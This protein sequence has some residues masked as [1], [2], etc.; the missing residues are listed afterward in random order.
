MDHSR[1]IDS[2]DE[3]KTLAAGPGSQSPVPK[4]GTVV[5]VDGADDA[6]KPRGVLAKL[7]HYEQL[8]DKKLG[9][10]SQSL[11]RR[12]PEGRDP[13]FRSWKTKIMMFLMWLSSCSNLCCFATGFLGYEF[14]LDL[15]TFLLIM[16]FANLFGCLLPV[17]MSYLL[18]SRVRKLTD[19]GKLC[20]LGP[21]DGSSVRIYD[22]IFHGLVWRQA[23]C[24]FQHH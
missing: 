9:V 11:E 22:A 16:I 12:T 8:L 14:G 24:P 21:Q 1:G 4:A 3:E 10:E 15:K 6:P 13:N 17:R 23:H 18:I 19:P 7:L 2:A 20:H 5:K